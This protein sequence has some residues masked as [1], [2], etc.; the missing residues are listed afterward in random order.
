M[1]A[2]S[3]PRHALGRLEEEARPVS[4]ADEAEVER[5]ER[6]GVRDRPLSAAAR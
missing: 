5:T 4:A 2:R 1:A 3:L 6:S